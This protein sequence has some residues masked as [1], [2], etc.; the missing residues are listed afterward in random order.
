MKY[1]SNFI[2]LKIMKKIIILTIFWS[3]VFLSGC[4]NKASN[5]NNAVLD[6]KNQDAG[7]IQKNDSILWKSAPQGDYVYDDRNPKEVCQNLQA[8]Q[9]L[10]DCIL[11]SQKRANSKEDGCVD[12]VAE[13]GCF[14]CKFDCSIDHI[15]WKSDSQGDEVLD[16]RDP[17]N[18]CKELQTEQNLNNCNIII[19][20]KSENREECVDG[21]SVAG[22]FACKFDC[23]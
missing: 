16:E 20:K 10:N 11:I 18:V 7:S 21:M 6:N 2:F 4:S 8:E 19:S 17:A 15:F 9:N 13:A 1:C 12:G 5:N 3:V 23:P 22:C 14:A